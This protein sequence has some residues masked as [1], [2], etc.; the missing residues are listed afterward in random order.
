VENLDGA[1]IACDL[2]KLTPNYMLGAGR[3]SALGADVRSRVGQAD[4]LLPGALVRGRFWR[5]WLP[6]IYLKPGLGC[7]TACVRY[8]REGRYQMQPIGEEGARDS[9]TLTTARE[10]PVLPSSS[11]ESSPSTGKK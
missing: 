4:P 11:L 6:D 7:L 9:V 5:E 3:S 2:Q 1:K 8:L 10:R